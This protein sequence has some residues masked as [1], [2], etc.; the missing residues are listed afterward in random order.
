[1]IPIK[2]PQDIAK[3]GEAGRILAGIMA[4]LA[5]RVAP[6]VTTASLDEAAVAEMKR[7]RVKSAFKGYRGYPASIC[8]SVNEEVVH[9]IP[10]CRALKEGDI[11]SVDIGIEKDGYFVDMARTFAVGAIDD[12]KRALIAATEEALEEA[13]KNLAAGKTLGCIGRTVEPYVKARGF[14]V[15]KDFV[16]HGIGRALHEEP[17]VPNFITKE[18]GPVLKNGMVLAIEPMVNAG[19]ADVVIQD[20]GWTAVTK[21]KKAS[22]H[23]EHTVALVDGAAVV[24][25]R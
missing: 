25:T 4:I 2:T 18:E 23:F 21:D 10:G 3:L 8:V 15:V 19:R 9:G 22:A 11:A 20:D 17:Q 7:L 13:I 24:L 6:G 14:S 5:G 12:V 16:G 1:V